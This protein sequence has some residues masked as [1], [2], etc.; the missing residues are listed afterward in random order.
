MLNY[1]WGLM[2]QIIELQEMRVVMSL[3]DL[4]DRI[5]NDSICL[6]SAQVR[7][8]KDILLHTTPNSQD[9]PYF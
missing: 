2:A 5:T 3:A 1:V 7:E 8:V 6:T 4:E 9:M